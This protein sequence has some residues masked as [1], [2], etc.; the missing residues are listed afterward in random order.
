MIGSKSKARAA[1]PTVIGNGTVIEGSV[2][3]AA[4]VRLH[5]RVEGVLIAEGDAI[6]GSTGS[7]LG[8]VMAEQLTLEGAIDGNVSVRGHLRVAPSGVLRGEV[9]YGTL[10]VERGG[11]LAGN[12]LHGEDVITIEAEAMEEV[13]DEPMSLPDPARA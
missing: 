1:E 13:E 10:Q 11:I 6:I 9:R 8:D 2:R 4:S 5:G 3:S 7:V 12:A